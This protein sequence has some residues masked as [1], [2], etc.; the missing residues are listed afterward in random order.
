MSKIISVNLDPPKKKSKENMVKV[1]RGNCIQMD[2]I[3]QETHTFSMD[4][5]IYPP[6][7]VK[8]PPKKRIITEDAR[9]KFSQQELAPE[10]GA[11]IIDILNQG[12]QIPEEISTHCHLVRQQITYKLGGYRQQDIEKKL[13]IPEEFVKFSKVLK[14]LLECDFKCHYCL[15]PVKIIYEYVRDPK[16]WTLDRISNDL[17]HNEGNLWIACLSCNL[18]RRTM[19][20]DRYEFTKQLVIT[21]K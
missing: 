7:K 11:K 10:Y 18:K 20:P 12:S 19:R 3:Q 14:T 5:Y 6:I 1:Y 2:T 15:E 16:Q 13:Y 9:W 8:P 21:K 17:G 4:K